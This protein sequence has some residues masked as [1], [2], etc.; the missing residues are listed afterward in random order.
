MTQK[1]PWPS[2][3]LKRGGF[4]RRERGGGR[5]RERRVLLVLVFLFPLLPSSFGCTLRERGYQAVV[6]RRRLVR[7]VD[8]GAEEIRTIAFI[9]E[10][11]VQGVRLN[12]QCTLNSDLLINF[13]L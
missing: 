13:F 6:G 3:P 12:G 11:G 4:Q 9:R 8:C 2:S 10:S 5:G 1:S 7:P